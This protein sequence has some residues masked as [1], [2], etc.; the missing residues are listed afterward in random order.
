MDNPSETILSNETQELQEARDAEL[1]KVLKLKMVLNEVRDLNLGKD[2]S[3]E[4]KMALKLI[5]ISEYRKLGDE[6]EN[7]LGKLRNKIL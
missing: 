6:Q 4:I 2:A 7:V 5:S 3:N 1:N